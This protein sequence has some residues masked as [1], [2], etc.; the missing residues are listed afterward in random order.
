VLNALDMLVSLSGGSVMYEAMSCGVCVLSAGFSG[1]KDAM[2]LR[3]GVTGKVIAT[4]EPTA[5]AAAV[6][7]LVCHPEERRR[8]GAA[9][10]R[11]AK[12]RLSHVAMATRTIRFYD[13]LLS[14]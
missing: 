14:G 10:R 6:K 9:A 12:E 11:W 2:H 4:Q 5:L 8:L 13:R 3:D 1:P 7:H